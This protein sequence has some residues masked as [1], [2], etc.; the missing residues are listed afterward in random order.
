MTNAHDVATLYF[1]TVS[2]FAYL[3]WKALQ[4]KPF[5]LN[6]RP[7]PVV[8]GAILGHWGQLGPAE[9]GPKRLHTYRYC[10]WLADREGIPFRFP[11]AHPFRSLDSL[12]LIAALDNSEAAIDAVFDA[13]FLEGL[14]L[15]V[16][17]VLAAV[18]G[19]LGVA[20]VPALIAAT[21][22]PARLRANTDVAIAEGVFGVPT[23]AVRGELFWG[24][25]A[26]PMARDYLHRP[27]MFDQPEMKRLANL[28]M[29][30][31]RSGSG[32]SR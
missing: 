31:Q 3:M 15:A 32:L 1:D 21:E 6:I 10:Q 24:F 13:I 29:G 17:D 5:E 19:R 20:D 28:P 18:G 23:L 26:L 9:I 11:P 22:A 12:R 2:P 27:D 7:V 8:F 4:R 16:P 14:D 25:D 30:V